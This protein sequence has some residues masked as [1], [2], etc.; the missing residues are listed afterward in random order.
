MLV[1]KIAEVGKNLVQG[2]WN[3]ILD[4]KDWLYQK[5][6]SFATGILD[7]ICSA[8]GIE[9]P[10]K[11]FRDVVGKNMALGIGVGFEKTIPSIAEEMTKTMDDLTSTISNNISIGEIPNVTRTITHENNY[12][13]KNYSNLTEVIRQPSTVIL[14]IDNKELGRVIVPAYEKEKVRLGVSLA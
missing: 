6:V 13:T 10:S 4:L 11:V 8:L 1:T 9:S 7:S 12:I 3:G 14:E 5:V 2:L